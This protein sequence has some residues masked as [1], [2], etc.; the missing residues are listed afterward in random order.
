L[1]FFVTLRRSNRADQI[2]QIKSRKSNRAN[3]KLGSSHF[4]FWLEPNC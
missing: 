3:K 1:A 2:A 4:Q